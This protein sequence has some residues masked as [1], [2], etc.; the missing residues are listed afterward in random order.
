MSVPGSPSGDKPG[1][2][3]IAHRAANRCM[4]PPSMALT[5]PARSLS[6]LA[7]LAALAPSPLALAEGALGH[8]ST[9]CDC[10]ATGTV[11]E[12]PAEMAIM[13]P[14]P[15]PTGILFAWK[16]MIL[17]VR[18]DSGAGQKFGSDS[19]Q[20]NRFLLRYTHLFDEL[21]PF[22]GRVELEG[23][24]F[25][26][27]A[28]DV[29]FPGSV[30]TDWTARAMGGAAQRLSQGI[31]IFG[32]AGIISRYQHG[33]VSGGSPTVGVVGAVANSELEFRLLPTLTASVFAEAALVP[34]SYYAQTNLGILSDCSEF[35]A[36]VQL[37][38]DFTRQLAAD[39][40]F[41]FTRWHSTWSQSSILDASNPNQA[42]ILEDREYTLTVGVRWKL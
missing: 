31:T 8:S 9:N 24:E 26:T 27:D 10:A 12:P 34:W 38:M 29:F 30:G 28:A 15:I 4:L 42:L 18:V 33:K 11:A 36:R 25:R 22:V 21:Q 14:Q 13:V 3:P 40:G 39:L 7:A 35:R 32:T 2:N 6:C 17:T 23:G 1:P 16:P 37:S 41:D 20:A 19:L 5:R